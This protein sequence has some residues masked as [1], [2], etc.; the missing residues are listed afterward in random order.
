MVAQESR[1]KK[2]LYSFCV[3]G[4]FED[5]EPKHACWAVYCSAS[6]IFNMGTMNCFL[7]FCRST[8]VKEASVHQTAACAF[9]GKSRWIC[10]TKE[11]WSPQEKMNRI[12]SSWQRFFQACSTFISCRSLRWPETQGKN[13][14]IL[15][16]DCCSGA[17][18]QQD[19]S[20]ITVS[21]K[22][23]LRNLSPYC[24]L[25]SQHH[26]FELYQLV[27]TI[28]CELYQATPARNL[29]CLIL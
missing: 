19:Q 12:C 24:S 6:D 3:D 21:T 5:T 14:W 8:T 25:G 22:T 10:K 2:L 1:Q 15:Q 26:L 29:A 11:V 20:L 7:R 9:I 17:F 18:P 4:C 23:D 28:I 27:S 13:P 16:P